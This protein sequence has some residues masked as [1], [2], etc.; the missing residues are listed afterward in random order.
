M[1]LHKSGRCIP[2][3]DAYSCRARPFEVPQL[4]EEHPDDAG[5]EPS[6]PLQN[7]MQLHVGV[8]HYLPS[9]EPFPL[10][11]DPNGYEPNTLDIVH[12]QAEMEYWLGVLEQQIGTG[13][14]KAIACEGCS[15]GETS[16][17]T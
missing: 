13:V 16:V 1:G 11:A 8:L 3:P 15:P 6:S 12:D 2:D 4:G 14:E 9:S 17:L 10:L 5:R 7:Q